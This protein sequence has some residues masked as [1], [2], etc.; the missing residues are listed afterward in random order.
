[1]SFASRLLVA[2]SLLA[3]AA[4]AGDL[5]P[6]IARYGASDLDGVW[7]GHGALKS[8]TCYP[9]PTIKFAV[10]GGRILMDG[11]TH[12]A[13]WQGGSSKVFGVVHQDK[14]VDITIVNRSGGGRTSQAWGRIDPQTSEMVIDDRGG[15]TYVYKLKRS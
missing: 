9:N 15:C 12:G 1:M 8:G 2:C 13:F 10:K 7:S 5:P 11:M 14:S 3:G 6:N 4:Y